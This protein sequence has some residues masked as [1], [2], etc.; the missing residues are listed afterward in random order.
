MSESRIKSEIRLALGRIPFARFFNNPVGQAWHG[1]LIV[2]KDP[3][4]IARFGRVIITYPTKITYGLAVGSGDLIG[5]CKERF[6]SIEVKDIDGV[7]S[8]E[9]IQWA[10]VVRSH[11]GI[12]GVARSAEEAK[13]LL[14]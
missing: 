3:R 10:N 9:Q 5:F 8:K 7:S 13:E 14:K 4:D 11:G 2:L 1:K 6:A 12:A